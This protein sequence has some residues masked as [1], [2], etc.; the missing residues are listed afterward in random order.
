MKILIPKNFNWYNFVLLISFIIVIY[1]LIFHQKRK[2]YENFTSSDSSNNSATQQLN[3]YFFYTYNC[4][5]SRKFF[6]ESWKKLS[7]KYESRIVFDAIDCYHPNTKGICK[8]FN[9]KN[10]PAIFIVNDSSD[11]NKS[12]QKYKFTGE[13]TYDNI[14][15]F[16]I[17]HLNKKENHK[18]NKNTNKENFNNN[19]RLKNNESSSDV[20]F[21]KN[22]DIDNKNFTYCIKYKDQEK[23]NL[24]FCQNIDQKE[25]PTLNGWQAAYSTMSHYLEKNA[26]TYDE[27]KDLAYKIKNDISNWGLCDKSILDTVKKN[28]TKLE[29]NQEDSDI[30][31]AINYGCGFIP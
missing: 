30:N 29:N 18:N 23:S 26:N 25:T 21:E 31:Q 9:V 6:D 16:I 20:E 14:E 11:D 28:N 10:V 3:F 13:R 17:T 7:D 1:F 8:A 12:F 4:P 5:H 19:S 27:K 22:E 24:N 15:Q 2:I